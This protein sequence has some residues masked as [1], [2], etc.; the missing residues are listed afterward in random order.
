MALA[1]KNILRREL[2]FDRVF[3]Q[4]KAVKGSFLF[5]K[6]LRNNLATPRFGIIVSTKVSKK[7]VERNRIR[8]ILAET[9]RLNLLLLGD[10]DVLAVTDKQIIGASSEQIR[11]DLLSV[12]NNL[13]K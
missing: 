4:G 6:Y 5:I 8:R 13:N 7:A 10:Y 9:I 3:K 11:Q 2:D 1:K 12:L